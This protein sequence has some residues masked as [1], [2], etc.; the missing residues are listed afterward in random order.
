MLCVKTCCHK[1]G[2][3]VD[4]HGEDLFAAF[5]NYRDLVEVNNPISRRG[6]AASRLPIRDQLGDAFFRKT[7]LKSPSLF[8][9][10][11]FYR[12]SQHAL[13]SRGLP[14]V[15]FLHALGPWCPIIRM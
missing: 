3:F 11:F 12:D 10:F 2:P 15:N 1:R 7:A 9:I 4:H 13:V 6:S 8:G 5:V 14:S